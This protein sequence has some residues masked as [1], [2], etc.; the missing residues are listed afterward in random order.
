[1]DIDIVNF[2]ALYSY[3]TVRNRVEALEILIKIIGSEDNVL[4][5]GN[6]YTTANCASDQRVTVRMAQGDY[7]ATG[8]TL[9]GCSFRPVNIQK[10][11]A[12]CGEE[13]CAA[14]N[15]TQPTPDRALPIKIYL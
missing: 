4:C 10:R 12:G 11:D 2:S 8:C 7:G 9:N 6:F 15:E 5:D 14:G 3:E 13:Q 1:M